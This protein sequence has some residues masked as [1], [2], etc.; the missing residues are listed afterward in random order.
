MVRTANAA[1]IEA[2]T[3][4]QRLLAEDEPEGL[5]PEDVRVLVDTTERVLW[6]AA[7]M[8]NMCASARSLPKVLAQTRCDQ[9]AADIAKLERQ[10]AELRALLD[11]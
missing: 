6:A 7:A 2:L 8:A 11:K 4:H 10:R 1:Y 9:I 5:P 3:Q